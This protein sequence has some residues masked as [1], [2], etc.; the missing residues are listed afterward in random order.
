M[1]HGLVPLGG[2]RGT[3]DNTNQPPVTPAGGRHK[4]V[5]R[6]SGI[7]GFE[8][9]HTA[10]HAEEAIVVWVSPASVDEPPV[11]KEVVILRVVAQQRT[12]Q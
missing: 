7:P 10:I 1:L 2:R 11:P 5:T 12:S 8:A 6:G 4:I 3:H 9:I